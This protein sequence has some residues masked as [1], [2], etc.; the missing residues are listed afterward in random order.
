MK[1]LIRHD[2]QALIDFC[3]SK[4]EKVMLDRINMLN[5]CGILRSELLPFF[6][7]ALPESK[8]YWAFVRSKSKREN[9][10]WG[11]EIMSNEEEMS[12]GLEL[13]MA[14]DLVAKVGT[15]YAVPGVLPPLMIPLKP[16]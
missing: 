11:Q 7:P 5:T 15:Q 14:F 12:I 8:E 1:G 16:A 10:L 13:L 6:W 3:I 2:R 4:G 9:D